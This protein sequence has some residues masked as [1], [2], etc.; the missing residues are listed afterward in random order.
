M[1]EQEIV[2]VDFFK[3][4]PFTA[5]TTGEYGG[6]DQYDIEYSHLNREL[7]Y[8][9][10]GGY[11]FPFEHE[12][13]PSEHHYYWLNPKYEDRVTVIGGKRIKG[14]KYAAMPWEYASEDYC[15]W[16]DKCNDMRPSEG[17]WGPCNHVQWC[18]ECGDW[19]TQNDDNHCEHEIE[20]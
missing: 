15:I 11:S 6:L 3:R 5:I 20:D 7:Y 19:K 2:L 10:S 18:D 9:L 13:S 12:M 14:S 16:C 1:T 8:E 4:R 17:T